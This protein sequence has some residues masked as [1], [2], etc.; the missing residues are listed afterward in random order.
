MPPPLTK[1][2]VCSIVL[3]S[4]SPLLV[5]LKQVVSVNPLQPWSTA[6]SGLSILKMDESGI[7]KSCATNNTGDVRAITESYLQAASGRWWC[8]LT[9]WL[10]EGWRKKKVFT[11]FRVQGSVLC[12]LSSTKSS[13]S[14][15]KK[16]DRMREGPGAEIGFC[17]ASRCRSLVL[18][19]GALSLSASACQPVIT[20]S[21]QQQQQQ[22]RVVLPVA[23]SHPCSASFKSRGRL[24]STLASLTF[25]PVTE[26]CVAIGCSTW[27]TLWPSI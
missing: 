25:L 1:H 3:D 16:R 26:G 21:A 7:N 22:Q 18:Y 4:A 5:L 17:S 11:S 20:C 2:A 15:E 10:E 24:S 12:L 19:N 23:L 13:G 8:T 9:T 27:N 6:W 14:M